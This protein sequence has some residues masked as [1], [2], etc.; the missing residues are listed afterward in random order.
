[1]RNAEST[2]DALDLDFLD[3]REIAPQRTGALSTTLA[4]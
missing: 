4:W 1:M 3:V 2:S